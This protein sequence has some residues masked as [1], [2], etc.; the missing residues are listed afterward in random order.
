[1]KMHMIS[2]VWNLQLSIA[3]S[4]L[5]TVFKQAYQHYTLFYSQ[6]YINMVNVSVSYT[7]PAVWKLQC[8][9][10]L[11]VLPL[12]ADRLHPQLKG[13]HPCRPCQSFPRIFIRNTAFTRDL[14]LA[15]YNNFS[16]CSTPREASYDKHRMKTRTTLVL[17]PKPIR[18]S[19]PTT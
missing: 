5:C 7:L 4:S 10:L 1:M 19:S 3:A 15:M 18:T 11:V 6:L 16:S 14:I 2:P 12:P 17:Q 9:A 13:I 8:S